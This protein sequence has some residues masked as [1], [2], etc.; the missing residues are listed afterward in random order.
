MEE[1]TIKI[2]KVRRERQLEL[3]KDKIR[4]RKRLKN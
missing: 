2:Q 4:E 1:A 3:L